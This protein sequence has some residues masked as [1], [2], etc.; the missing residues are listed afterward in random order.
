MLEPDPSRTGRLARL[1]GLYAIVGGKDPVAQ[2]EQALAGGAAVVQLR[3]KDAKPGQVLEAARRIVALAAGRGLVLV[4]DRAD[5]ALLSDADG[6]HVG[7]DDLPVEE[8][9]RLLGPGRLVGWTAR[10]VPEA[11][12]GLARGADH[13]GFGPVFASHTKAMGPPPHEVAG[14]SAA[15]AAIP[16]PVVAISG[17]DLGRIGAVARAGAACAA[18]IEAIYGAGDARQNAQALAAAFAAGR[19]QASP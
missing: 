5:L 3:M 14:L 19:K 18:V 9:R 4:N 11:L 12:Q 7:E 16:A 17:I 13:V 1:H 6:V 15:C 8:A 10:T 2:A